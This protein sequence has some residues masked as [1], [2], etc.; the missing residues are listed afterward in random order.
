MRWVQAI[1]DELSEPASWGYCP[2]APPATEPGAMAA[3]ALAGHG[4]LEAAERACRW[5]VSLQADDG[6]LGIS[7]AEAAPHWPTGL[8]ILAWKANGGT[9]EYETPI[10]RALAWLLATRGETTP[11]SDE[12]GHDTMAIGWPWVEGTHAWVEPTAFNVLALKAVGHAAHPRARWG[13]G[14]LVDRLLKSGGCN[15]GNTVVLGQTLR[16]HVEPTGLAL[17]ALAGESDSTGNIMR[18]IDY[19]EITLDRST[20]AASLAYGLMGLAAHGRVPMAAGEWLASAAERTRRRGDSPHRLALL[21]MA[22]LG[23]AC[24]ILQGT[25]H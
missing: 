5:L 6:T 10:A 1:L 2:G 22:A 17:A 11:R 18:A 12:V 9:A 20:T 25:N 24:P 15:Y 3:M 13:A 14:L 21:A 19:L 8:A 23:T 4:R 16:A 7:A